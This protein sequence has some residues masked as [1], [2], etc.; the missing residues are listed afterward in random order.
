MSFKSLRGIIGK[1]QTEIA[2]L[3]W[4]RAFISNNK[5]AGLALWLS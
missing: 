1:I 2:G 5:L 3:P 4:V